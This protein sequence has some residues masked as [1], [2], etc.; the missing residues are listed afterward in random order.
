M[1][2]SSEVISSQEHTEYIAAI[3]LGSNSFHMVVAKMVHGELKIVD[4]LGEKVQLGAG[5]NESGEITDEAKDRAIACLERFSQRIREFDADSV[6]I[7]GTNALRAAKKKKEFLRLA[8]KAI[9]YPIDII[10]GREEARLIYLGVAHTLADDFGN[11]L[12][13]DIGGGSTEL[14]IGERFENKALESL[15][16][17]CVSFRERYFP[18]GKL[19]SFAF[20]RAIRH[21]S[22]ELLNIKY[23]FSSVGWESSVGASGSI[24]AIFQTVEYLELKRENGN[25]DLS[26]LKKL[27]EK[28]I[29]L[30]HISGLDEF[31]I[32]KERIGIFPAGLAILYACFEVFKIKEMSFT[33][34]ALREG[35]LYD[36]VGRIQHEDVRERSINS[37]QLQYGLDK[38]RAERVEE[39][40]LNIYNQVAYKWGIASSQNALLL[41]W[42][43]RIFEVGLTISHAQ[44]HK[45]GAYLVLHSDL[46]GFTKST[47]LRLSMIVRAHRR[48]FSDEIFQSCAD[49]EKIVLK[50]L[51]VLFR[52]AVVLTVARKKAE[53]D[54][55]I[56]VEGNHV[57]LEM[58]KEWFELYPLNM[59]NLETEKEYLKKQEFALMIQ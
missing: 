48:K 30:E 27:K 40:V 43:S 50:K 26:V 16:M 35:L 24:K 38:Q 36:M 32:K 56:N 58:R 51:C 3:D 33:S 10:S 54:F 1:P 52:L 14:I 8:E 47:Q 34:G 18:E 6:Q 22:R 49:V 5:L 9:G 7:V 59:A 53:T 39:T 20:N 57:T 44:Y 2:N 13:I 29:K 19:T 17:G 42:A 37:M 46:S 12:V 41:K 23:Q 31:G 15:H 45:H 11:R 28:M 55:T 4:K 21:A 25:I